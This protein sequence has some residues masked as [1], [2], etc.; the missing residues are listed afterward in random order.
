MST[1][2]A[3]PD[4]SLEPDNYASRARASAPDKPHAPK[5]KTIG[6]DRAAENSSRERRKKGAA[7][8]ERTFL[9]RKVH[10]FRGVSALEK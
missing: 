6:S 10:A 9:G 1:C 4:G 8:P 5:R 2:A 7:E 3:L